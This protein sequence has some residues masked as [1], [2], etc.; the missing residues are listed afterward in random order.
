VQFS[1]GRD[2][3]LS[4]KQDG[5]RLNYFVYPYVEV[6]HKEYTNV[7]TRFSFEDEGA[8]PLRFARPPDNNNQ[9]RA[10]G[11][12][13]TGARGTSLLAVPPSAPLVPYLVP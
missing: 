1:V 4:P 13:G 7:S 12:H 8:Q 2:L 11:K 3:V 9:Q 5:D 6:D 10:Y